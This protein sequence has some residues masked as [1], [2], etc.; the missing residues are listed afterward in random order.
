MSR[1][2]ENLNLAEQKYLNKESPT[3]VELGQKT[4]A[5]FKEQG[6]DLFDQSQKKKPGIFTRMKNATTG[7]AKKLSNAQQ[8][9]ARYN[10]DAEQYGTM[11]ALGARHNPGEEEEEEQD[12]NSLFNPNNQQQPRNNPN[13]NPNNNNQA[14]WEQYANPIW[15]KM[16]MQDKRRFNND[17]NE[18]IKFLQDQ[19]RA[20]GQQ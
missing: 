13:N 20:G 6:G 5:I 12:G 3:Q 15:S 7:V 14:R 4:N 10:Q 8:S 17:M 2:E 1:F 11:A 16:T 19:A 9:L 18:Y